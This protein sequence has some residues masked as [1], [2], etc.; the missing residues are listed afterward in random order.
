MPGLGPVYGSRDLF[1][2]RFSLSYDINGIRTKEWTPTL[3]GGFVLARRKLF[4]SVSLSRGWIS[5]GKGGRVL[6]PGTISL[7]KPDECLLSSS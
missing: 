1:S 5:N 4:Q 7:G 3:N 6:E 2:D